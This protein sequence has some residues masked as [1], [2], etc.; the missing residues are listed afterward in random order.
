MSKVL[1]AMQANKVPLASVWNY[2]RKL[3]RDPNSLSFDDDTAP[4]LQMI[5]DF[6]QKWS[7]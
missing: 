2:G 6:N 7:R 5:G 1:G 4:V 3:M